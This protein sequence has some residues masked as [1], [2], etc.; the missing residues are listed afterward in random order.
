MNSPRYLKCFD[1]RYLLEVGPGLLAMILAVVGMLIFPKGTPQR[2]FLAGFAGVAI[3]YMVLVTVASIRRLD[4]LQQRI[5]LIS[6]AASFAV[7]GVLVNSVPLFTKAGFPLPELGPWL[8]FVM[9]GVWAGG[10][11]FVGRRYR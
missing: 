4:E 1:R 7:T 10:L 8:W 3:A 6:I 5:H 9:V 2:P 11:F